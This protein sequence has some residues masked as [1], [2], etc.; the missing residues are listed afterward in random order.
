MGYIQAEKSEALKVLRVRQ[1]V[2][3][4]LMDYARVFR[5]ATNQRALFT[6]PKGKMSADRLRLV[7][8]KIGM[9]AGIPKLHSDAFGPQGCH[10]SI[11]CGR[12]S[13]CGPA[14]VRAH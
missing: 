10:K 13:S 11:Q 1:N 12:R 2:I 9:E 3:S 8:K 5:P 14:V 7:V 4:D 6:G